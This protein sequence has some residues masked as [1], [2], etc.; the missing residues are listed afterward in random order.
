MSLLKNITA[1]GKQISEEIGLG[2][3]ALNYQSLLEKTKKTTEEVTSVGRQVFGIAQK[4]EGKFKDRKDCLFWI[5]QVTKQI[6]VNDQ[7]LRKIKHETVY[8]GTISDMLECGNVNAAEF[9]YQFAEELKRQQTNAEHFQHQS[10]ITKRSFEKAT[11]VKR[12]SEISLQ[13]EKALK[14]P[15]GLTDREVAEIVNIINGRFPKFVGFDALGMISKQLNPKTPTKHKSKNPEMSSLRGS[16]VQMKA[17]PQASHGTNKP[18]VVKETLSTNPLFSKNK[19]VPKKELLSHQKSPS[20]Q[21][22]LANQERPSHQEPKYKT[23]ASA[24]LAQ[25][26]P[27]KSLTLKPNL[28]PYSQAISP[29]QDDHIDNEKS[30]NGSTFRQES[31]VELNEL[32]VL[33]KYP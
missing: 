21:D 1:F 30:P 9:A 26:S 10:E 14:T 7:L 33:L 31:P 18:N 2:L 22:I 13:N 27:M 24:D 17:F 23:D 20:K 25:G 32:P 6:L 3:A 16:P 19:V 4:A 5:S 12:S 8:L 15:F 28:G 29:K 11:A